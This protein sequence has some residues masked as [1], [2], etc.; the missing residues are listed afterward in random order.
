VA[1]PVLGLAKG[2]TRGRMSICDVVHLGRHATTPRR[3][4]TRP[5]VGQIG[6]PAMLRRSPDAPHRASRR[7]SPDEPIWLHQIDPIWSDNALGRR[8]GFPASCRGF[9]RRRRAK[10]PRK[11]PCAGVGT[12]PVY[13]TR[14]ATLRRPRV[15]LGLAERG[16]DKANPDR[17][18]SRQRRSSPFSSRAG[19]VFL[20]SRSWLRHSSPLVLFDNVCVW[21]GPWITGSKARQ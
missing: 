10:R 14:I 6:P 19:F 12:S 13:S 5:S 7:A 1:K 2:E 20:V 17:T 9:K 4:R 18:R 8:L 11:T 3:K 21:R 16:K 15:P